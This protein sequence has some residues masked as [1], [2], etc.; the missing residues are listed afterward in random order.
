MEPSEPWTL[1]PWPR[2]LAKI[3]FRESRLAPVV[4]ETVVLSPGRAQGPKSLPEAAIAGIGA[5]IIQMPGSF[6][7]FDNAFIVH[8]YQINKN[9]FDVIRIGFVA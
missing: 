3:S 1:V 8:S 6:L 2:T 4:K 9:C 7:S 5:S